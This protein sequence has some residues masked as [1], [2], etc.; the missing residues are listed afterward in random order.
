MRELYEGCNASCLLTFDAYGALGGV[1]GALGRRAEAV[2]SALPDEARAAFGDVFHAL[3]TVNASGEGSGLR[4]RAPLASIAAT[5]DQRTLVDALIAHRFLTADR[6]GDLPIVSLTHEA[7]IRRW[8]R[9]ANWLAANREYLRLRARIEQAQGHWEQEHQDPSLLLPAGLPLAEGRTLL[10]AT[11]GLLSSETTQFIRASIASHESAR[12]RRIRVRRTVIGALTL[13]LVLISVLGAAAVMQRLNVEAVQNEKIQT[14]VALEKE[15]EQKRLA[16]RYRG[17]AERLNASLT[18]QKG[19]AFSNEGDAGRGMLWMA[20]GL[21]I[22]PESASNLERAIRSALASAAATVHTLESVFLV[23]GQGVLATFS[24]DGKTLLFGGKGAS[25]ID[26]ATGQPRG[27]FQ[28]SVR[29]VSGGDFSPDGGLFVT[30]TMGGVIRVADATSGEDIGPTIT[31]R[32]TVKSVVFS[33]DGKTLLAAAQFGLSLQCYD[34]G[35]RRPVGPAFAC[36]ENLYSAAYSPDGRRIATAAMESTARLWDAVTGEPL[37]PPLAHP[38]LVFAATFSPDGKTLL[39]GCLDGAARFWSVESGKPFGPILRHK[40]PVRSAVFSRD[41]RL[42]LT[43]SEDGTARLWEVATGRPVGQWLSHSGELRHASFSPDQTHILT[44]GFDGDARLW[45]LASEESLARVLPQPGAVAAIAFSPDGKRVLTGCQESEQRPGESRLWDTATGAPV[46]PPL[47]QQGQ[48]MQVAFS[49]DE[50]LALTAGNDRTVRLWNANDSTPARDPWVYGNVVAAV[51][52]SPDGRLAA[53]GGRG[54][55]IQLREVARGNIVASWQAYN[56]QGF[57]VWTLQFSPD[58][59]TLL[60]GGGE[61]GRLWSMPDGRPIGQPM[62]H[63]LEARTA[64]LSP[65]GQI[66]LT[67]SDDKTARLWSA[68]DGHP[69]SPPLVHQGLVRAGSFRPDGKIVATAAGDGTVRLWEVPSG[70]S[71]LPPLL[72][73]SW[74]RSVAFSPDGRTLATGSDDETARLWSAEDGTPLGAVLRH[75]GPVNKVAFSHDGRIV[76]TASSDGTARLWTPPPPVS[77]DRANVVMR[78]QVLTGLELN[79]EGTMQVMSGDAWQR[80]RR[81]LQESGAPFGIGP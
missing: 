42:A 8:E 58:G 75:R 47:L 35:T 66:V 32:G 72:H 25:L 61:E 28:N 77:G 64:V 80:R 76:L 16:D 55:V 20:R 7:L 22:C 1:D 56:S 60:S 10:L 15:K 24:P 70:R 12:S 52:I 26:A 14:E 73:D 71:L 46:G 13:L 50:K 4:R 33:P 27:V 38:G 45:R 40:G 11:P 81:Q 23:S 5:P 34:V 48:V 63:A 65:D 68:H 44:A 41:G 69:L 62:Q 53:V 30:S 67:C 9:L 78:V 2:F 43:S 19:T 79:A 57:W 31:H 59:R 17:E 36:R 21:D 54:G 39:T 51:A 3:V 37:G 29:P 6:A 74:V 18:F 49:P